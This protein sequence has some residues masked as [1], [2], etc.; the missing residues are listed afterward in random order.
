MKATKG[1]RNGGQ[2]CGIR[3]CNEKYMFIRSDVSNEK[4]AFCTL[5]RRGGGG[6]C[7]AQTDKALLV[8]VWHKDVDMSNKM[9]QNTGDCEKN[10]LNVA[11]LLKAAGY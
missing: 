6:A 5:G 8:G 1:T 4:V 3:I 2:E 7:V 9:C 10:V 11:H